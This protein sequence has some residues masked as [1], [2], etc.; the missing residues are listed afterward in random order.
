MERFLS[1]LLQ[2][3]FLAAGLFFCVYLFVTLKREIQLLA[4]RSKRQHQSHDERARDLESNLEQMRSTIQQAEEHG[5]PV[6]LP[7]PSGMNLSKRTQ[8]LRLARRGESPEHI[9]AAL[10]LPHR[11]VELILKVHGILAASL[12]KVIS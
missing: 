9:A 2:Y 5:A 6:P 10:S 4:S 8:T 11:E 3:F 1:P 7:I 12:D